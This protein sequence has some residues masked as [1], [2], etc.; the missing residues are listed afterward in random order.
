[1]IHRTT[2]T[3]TGVLAAGI[4][5]SACSGDPAGAPATSPTPM[6]S[7]SAS[8]DASAAASP[9]STLS[10]EEQKAFDEATQVVLAYEQTFYDVLASPDPNLNDINLVATEPALGI[11]LRQ[12][13]GS[14]Q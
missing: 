4:L 9:S 11:A 10:A 2:R 13:S 3:L 14:L 6:P 5:L 1:M 7:T 8:A 12:S